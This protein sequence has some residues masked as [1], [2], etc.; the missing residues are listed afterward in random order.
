MKTLAIA[1]L[2]ALSLYGSAAHAEARWTYSG[3]FAPDAPIFKDSSTGEALRDLAGRELRFEGVFG[4]PETLVPLKL[5][6]VSIGSEALPVTDGYVAYDNAGYFHF[7]VRPSQQSFDEIGYT[8]QV[9]GLIFECDTGPCSIL[10]GSSLIQN[11]RNGRYPPN[12]QHWATAGYRLQ[13]SALVFSGGVPEPQTW[14]LFISGFGLVGAAFRARHKP[15]TAV[16]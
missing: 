8:F 13:N 3:H 14:A 12:I 11:L 7:Y 9:D 4:T 16:A 15:S 10:L 1:A 2:A 5:T 6:R